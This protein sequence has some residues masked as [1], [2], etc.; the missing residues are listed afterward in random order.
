MLCLV[1]IAP[2]TLNGQ[3]DAQASTSSEKKV[4]KDNWKSFELLISGKYYKLFFDYKQLQK[5]GWDFNLSDYGYDNYIMNP[6]DKTYATIDLKNKNYDSA[7]TVG[8]QNTGKK[9]LGIKKCK[10]WAI[11]IDNTYAKKPVKFMLPKGIKQGSTLKQVVKA[12]GKPTDKY[13]SDDLKY[14]EY[15]YQIDY[16]SHLRLTIYDKKGLVQME[17]ELYK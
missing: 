9:A 13:R 7:M 17:Y 14:W 5:A 3:I 16:S 2:F 10:V 4:K 6:N 11:A 12:Y 8:F 15:T 1:T